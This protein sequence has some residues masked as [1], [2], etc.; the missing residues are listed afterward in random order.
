VRAPYVRGWKK[1]VFTVWFSS[2]SDIEFFVSPP[3]A[4]NRKVAETAFSRY[5]AAMNWL[6]KQEQLV[7]CVVIGLL[8]TGLA[9]KYHRATAPAGTASQSAKP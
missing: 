2:V 4:E 8:L 1:A 9:V 5:I 7:L 6:T 3:G